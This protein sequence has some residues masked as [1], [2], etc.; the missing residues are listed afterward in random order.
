M[1]HGKKSKTTFLVA[2]LSLML[3]IACGAFIPAAGASTVATMD[4]AIDIM[5]SISGSISEDDLVELYNNRDELV[6]AASMKALRVNMENAGL[7][8]VLEPILDNFYI[9]SAKTC[10]RFL[11]KKDKDTLAGDLDSIRDNYDVFMYGEDGQGGLEQKGVDDTVIFDFLVEL[12]NKMAAD[13][14]LNSSNFERRIVINT[15]NIIQKSA[16]EELFNGLM[17]DLSEEDVELLT[18]LKLPSRFKPLANIVSGNYL[19]IVKQDDG[20]NNT[21]GGG[22]GTGGAEAAPSVSQ[23][24]SSWAKE[25][26]GVTE[27]IIEASDKGIKITVP[28]AFA[29]LKEGDKYLIK[30][31]SDIKAEPNTIE[32]L[33]NNYSDAGLVI[34]LSVYQDKGRGPL[35]D[36]FEKPFRLEL[37]LK[38]L[39]ISE[40]DTN[41]LGL[42]LYNT[43][44]NE[45]IYQGGKFDSTTNT[46]STTVGSSGNYIL[47]AYSPVFVDLSSHWS[48]AEVEVAAARHIVKGMDNSNFAPD[49]LVSRAQFT[50]MI[51]RA[52]RMK[53]PESGDAFT[54]VDQ[55]AW[56][57][58]E[59]TAA[60]KAGIIKGDE[61]NRF[62]PDHQ[63]NRLEMAVIIG[64]A[65]KYAGAGENSVDDSELLAKFVDGT[66]VPEWASG[67]IAPAIK[68]GL[69]NGKDDGE[70]APAAFSTRGEAAAVLKRL[71]DMI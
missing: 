36:A 1:F 9:A 67:E 47:L 15:I 40:I 11:A 32:K 33:G 70:L 63:I 41:K 62:N 23:Q 53:L 55:S 34:S 44:N 12:D 57:V 52:L 2:F 5:S 45:L 69:I 60:V 20:Q 56:F 21:S 31:D 37:S 26:D 29:P 61:G 17:A 27:E 42:Y 13:G 19:P 46:F 14:N 3:S 22:G 39:K 68:A 58:N 28:A 7:E 59:V 43:N 30:L 50:A 8:N 38:D 64:R 25:V 71:T 10:L 51:V 24:G 49:E 16:Y 54:D 35:L 66:E 18:S 48:R 4:D 65:L 6:E